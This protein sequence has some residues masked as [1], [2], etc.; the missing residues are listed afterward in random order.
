MEPIDIPAIGVIMRKL[1]SSIE[2]AMQ[3]SS[4]DAWAGTHHTVLKQKPDTRIHIYLEKEVVYTILIQ[5][6]AGDSHR[7]PAIIPRNLV[8]A[9]LLLSISVAN[10]R[11]DIVVVK[12]P[13]FDRIIVNTLSTR[14]VDIAM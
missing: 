6:P 12:H 1:V 10:I 2:D 14:A 5:R 8:P 3:G 9:E 4:F 7:R 13:A 11:I